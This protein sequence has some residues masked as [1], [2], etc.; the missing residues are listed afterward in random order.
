M[1]DLEIYS[2]YLPYKVKA[3][4]EFN[5]L[6]DFYEDGL[7][8]LDAELLRWIDFDKDNIKLILRPL[9]DLATN[10]EVLD[11]IYA[12]CQNIDENID[13]W[14][15]FKG[16]MVNTSASFRAIQILLKNHFDVFGL[17]EH[18]KAINI[19]TL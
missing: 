4:I 7:Y 19:N 14:C 8:F 11:L 9:S 1:T 2:A 17:I 12:E 13:Y 3:K 10:N 6:N 5:E 18:E 15:E 16:N